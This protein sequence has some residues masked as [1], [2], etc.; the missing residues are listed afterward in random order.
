[1][2]QRDDEAGDNK[3]GFIHL[4][5]MVVPNQQPAK[6]SQ[7][8]EGAFDLPP[9]SIAPQFPSVVA[10]RFLAFFAMRDDQQD[11]PLEQAPAQRVAVVA[12]IGHDA[13]SGGCGT[14]ILLSVFSAKAVGF[15]TEHPSRRHYHPLRACYV[16]FCR[17]PRPFFAGAK[18][19]SRKLSSQ[20]SVPRASSSERKAR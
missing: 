1:M 2:A 17:R 8:S 18:L 10:R 19:A 14:K 6:I 15:P 3:E 4:H 13:Q 5:L 12:P 11:A 16:W 9:V 7:P 20:S